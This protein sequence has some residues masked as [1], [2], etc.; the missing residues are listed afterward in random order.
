MNDQ[1]AFDVSGFVKQSEN[2]I[3]NES[4]PTQDSSLNIDELGKFRCFGAIERTK[5][6]SSRVNRDED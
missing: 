4:F 5:Q 6:L 1:S 2:V 3:T